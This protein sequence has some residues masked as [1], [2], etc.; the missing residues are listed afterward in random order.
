MR[1]LLFSLL[2]G[3]PTCALF[4]QYATLRG[5]VVD[6][7][8]QEPLYGA[9]LELVGD[10]TL[11]TIS[12]FGNAAFAFNAKP[13]TYRLRAIYVGYDAFEMKNIVLTANKIT[14]IEVKLSAA[15]VMMELSV[16]SAKK[17]GRSRK[18]VKGKPEPVKM[19]R[20][21]YQEAET[22]PKA[23][24]ELDRTTK[25]VAQDLV[26]DYADGPIPRPKPNSDWQENTPFLTRIEPFSTFSIDVDNASYTQTRMK[27]RQ[28]QK[29]PDPA[30][31]RIEELVNYFRY[32][33]PQPHGELPFAVFTELSDC[34][35]N[36]RAKL[37]HIGL[38]G[39][40]EAPTPALQL[41][42]SDSPAEISQKMQSERSNYVFLI[43]VSGSMSGTKL[44]L[45][46][47]AIRKIVEP[48]KAEDRAAI[49]VY[50]GAAGL[51]LPATPGS[52][53]QTI[54][55]ALN[56]L[57]AGGS[58]AGGAGVLL[59]YKTAHE[60][61]VAGANNRVILAT[62]GDF[63]VGVSSVADLQRLIEVE[64]ER[65]I[66]LSVFGVGTGGGYNDQ[67]MET[68]AD[69]GNGMYFFMD[70]IGE[71]QRIASHRSS[72]TT[73]AKDVKL[74]LEFDSTVVQMYRLVGY[75]NRL[76][77]KEDFDDDTKDAGELGEGHT[78]TAIYEIIPT[79]QARSADT[80]LR[81]RLR[82]KHPLSASSELIEYPI[83]YQPKTAAQMSANMGWATA[84]AAWG[85]LLRESSY[86]GTLTPEKVLELARAHACNDAE[87]KDA[88]LL[89]E[90]WAK[91]LEGVK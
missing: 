45:V 37:L 26:Q 88:L 51:V 36:S 13:G 89:M 43:D 68:L 14:D 11:Y 67:T 79:Q 75:E 85:M 21:F 78:V 12:D 24:P 32:D 59:A 5:Y 84:V 76:L 71:A 41:P 57:Q 63:N 3:L 6:L 9:N 7:E 74:Q 66:F 69:K 52:D 48:L 72:Y 2:L 53:K 83:L 82:Y 73:I 8:T 62:D 39:N 10:S 90:E 60:N 38:Q 86:R 18:R 64:R 16:V 56:R 28:E 22:K 61:Y 23:K 27:I 81:L 77:N 80:A 17:S 29:L 15:P 4:A 44:E 1:T 19:E 65:G 31:V 40:L 33:Y 20:Y 49:V 30:T 25:H 91:M 87:R 34:P 70:D 55:D 58:T 54:L 47:E 42:D 50:A 35:W 46:K